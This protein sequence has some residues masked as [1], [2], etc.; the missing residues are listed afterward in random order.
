M[1]PH[2]VLESSP[3]RI[4]L[5]PR[6]SPV[7]NAQRYFE[8]AKRARSAAVQTAERIQ[9]LEGQLLSGHALLGIVEEVTST[10]DLRK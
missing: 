5:D 3:L 4:K 9:E 7:K 6:L 8:K 1:R 10:E 2:I